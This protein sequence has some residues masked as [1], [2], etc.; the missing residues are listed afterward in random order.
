[1]FTPLSIGLFATLDFA[2]SGKLFLSLIE[3]LSIVQ[4]MYKYTCIILP[5]TWMLCLSRQIKQKDTGT[6]TW[7]CVRRAG[8]SIPVTD[9]WWKQ[10]KFNA[11]YMLANKQSFIK[12]LLYSL[13]LPGTFHYLSSLAAP[14]S[15]F[16]LLF[17]E[18]RQIS[19]KRLGRLATDDNCISLSFSCN[20][21]L[22]NGG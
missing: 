22:E 15:A 13:I 14:T 7:V 4:W 8:N 20:K 2:R 9:F 3:T 21:H 6:G 19:V 1:M 12:S 18:Q 5:T 10:I 11:C 16:Y 17:I